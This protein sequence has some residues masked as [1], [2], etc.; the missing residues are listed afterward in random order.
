[1]S[2][3]GFTIPTWPFVV[4]AVAMGVVTIGIAR[5]AAR[6]HGSIRVI[7]MCLCVLSGASAACSAVAAG[8]LTCG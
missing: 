4:V 8:L 7:A 3:I 5:W 6:A 1:V 2:D